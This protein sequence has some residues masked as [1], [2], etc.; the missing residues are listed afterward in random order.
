MTQLRQLEVVVPT[1]IY[2]KLQIVSQF[3]Q[4]PIR[5]IASQ[6]IQE[7]MDANYGKRVP[8]NP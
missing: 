7:W 1:S 5:D 2:S 8:G 3:D 4:I 6:A